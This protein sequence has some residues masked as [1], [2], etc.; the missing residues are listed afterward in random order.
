MNNFTYGAELEFY[1]FDSHGS[2]IADLNSGK[3]P[4]KTYS[5]KSNLS[6]NLENFKENLEYDL[7]NEYGPG[8]FEI[9]F[10]KTINYRSLIDEIDKAKQN[11]I[12][13]A[14]K[15]NM[16]AVFLPKPLDN[17]PGNGLHIHVSHPD[18][19]DE[20]ILLSAIAGC[21]Q[22]IQNDLPAFANHK[23]SI[24]RFV[25][26]YD[27]PTKIC[28]GGNN[29]TTAIRIPNPYDKRIEHR[30]ADSMANPLQVINAV[31][32][33]IQSGIEQQLQPSAKVWGNAFDDQYDY[34]L[35]IA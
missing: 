2:P 6:S 24:N 15:H 14:E 34:P 11:I 33:A 5:I 9:N 4:T 27:A 23:Q 35:I 8:Q 30:V 18:F 20:N 26:N 10:N 13:S 1:L 16:Q 12:Y 21:L 22:A 25:A 29:R 17:Q 7:Q 28:W 31:N 3:Y 32:K 19:N